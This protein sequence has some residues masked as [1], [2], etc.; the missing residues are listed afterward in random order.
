MN[1]Y[2]ARKLKIGNTPLTRNSK[3]GRQFGVTNLQVKDES[4]NPF[5]TFKDRRNVLVMDRA[6]QQHAD[7]VVIITSGNAG[8]SLARLAEKTSIK[9][10][11]VVDVAISSGI[12]ESLKRYAYRVIEVD[13]NER[14]LP[15]EDVIRLARERS[16][17]VVLDVTNN[18]EDAFQ[19]IA[20]EL[21]HDAPDYLV[22]PLGSGEAYAGL[23]Q[24]LKKHRLKTTLVGAGVHQLRD[25]E[26]LL[27]AKPSIADKLYTPFTPY[28]KKIISILGEGNLYFHVSDRQIIDAYKK[29][30]PV[31][32]CEPSS[33]AAFASLPKLSINKDSKV[34][35][36]NSGKGI[37]AE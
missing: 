19:S 11:C 18:Y 1:L 17:E 31:Y 32:S 35:V 37:W 10:V 2:E 4:K 6:I 33:A 20:A 15:T 8:Y 21:R 14:I 25:H 27:Q 28:R 34:V 9:V 30:G 16:D 22:T 7:K 23:Y 29:I 36:I 26:L 5:G 3:T 13:L 12:K 24:G